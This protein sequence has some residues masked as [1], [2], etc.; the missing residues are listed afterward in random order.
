MGDFEG[1][2]GGTGGEIG[3]QRKS[4][5]FREGQ[6]RGG[7]KMI[8]ILTLFTMF[9]AFFCPDVGAVKTASSELG[10]TVTTYSAYASGTAYT[11]TNSAAALTFGTTNPSLTLGKPGTYLILGSVNLAYNAATFGANQ[12]VT[13]TFRRT[14]NTAANLGTNRTA[15]TRVITTTT[16]SMGNFDLPP[17]IYSTLN[18][19][20]A[21][22]INGSVTATPSAGSLQA[23]EAEIVA[24][25]IR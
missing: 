20:D 18:A 23:T 1:G 5:G 17:F 9:S 10:P 4:H 21:I 13:L 7:E 2:Y 14:N 19:N 16:D 22:T 3:F 12:T 11:F 24:I 6:V 25:R 8:R 15:T